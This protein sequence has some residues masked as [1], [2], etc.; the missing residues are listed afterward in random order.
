MKLQQVYSLT[1]KAIDDYHMI[2]PNDKIAIGISGGKDS[3][4]LLYALQ[5]LRRFYPQPFD[6]CAVTVDLG[7]HNLNL[8]KIKELCASIDVE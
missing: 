7:F 4:T 1:R 8:D 6:L 3:L 2:E 5:G